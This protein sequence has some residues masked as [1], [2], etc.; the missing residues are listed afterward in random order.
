MEE[1]L[2]IIRRE[3]YLTSHNLCDLLEEGKID[4]WQ[5]CKMLR[6]RKG[7]CPIQCPDRKVGCKNA[8]ACRTWAE[9]EALT[10]RIQELKN[11]YGPATRAD[12]KHRAN[13]YR[14][15]QR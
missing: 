9:H 5:F 7:P 1:N 10:A 13:I 2:P 3:G 12:S 6:Y 4:F 15:G 8:A 11:R 14:L